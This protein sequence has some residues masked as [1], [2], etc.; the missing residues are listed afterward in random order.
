MDALRQEQRQWIKDRDRTAEVESSSFEGGTYESVQYL[1][2]LA[3]V[4]KERCYELV[5]DYMK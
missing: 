1:I 5:Y 3:R 2:T 4:T